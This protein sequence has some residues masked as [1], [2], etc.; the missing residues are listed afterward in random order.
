MKTAE[1]IIARHLA[2]F[3]VD[4]PGEDTWREYVDAART[5]LDD[6]RAEGYMLVAMTEAVELARTALRKQ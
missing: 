4:R 3:G 5:V 6:L 2:D 1:E